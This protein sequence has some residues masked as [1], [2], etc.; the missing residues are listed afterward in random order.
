MRKGVE[1]DGSEGGA[2]GWR[3]KVI[4]D[5]QGRRWLRKKGKDDSRKGGGRG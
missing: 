5:N 3:R 2:G 4:E 1:E